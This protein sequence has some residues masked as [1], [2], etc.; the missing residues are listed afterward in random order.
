M[1]V[2][3]AA[4]MVAIIEEAAVSSGVHRC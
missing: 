1:V 2:G 4:A 3:T